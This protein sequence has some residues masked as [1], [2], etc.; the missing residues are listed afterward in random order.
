MYEINCY[1]SYGNIITYLTQWDY[2]RQLSMYLDEYNLL[3]APE[4]H[5]CN[6]N[7]K[8]ALVVQSSVEDSKVTVDIPNILL[9]EHLPLF[10]YV[11]LSDAQNA[12]SQKT[13][14]STTIPIRQRPRPADY[15]Y[16]DNVDIITWAE[17]EERIFTRVSERVSEI[18]ISVAT[19]NTLGGIKAAK[20]TNNETVE[21]KIG[22]NGKLYVPASTN[23]IV[24]TTLTL[25]GTAAD[26]KTVG[27]LINDFEKRIK[28][29]EGAQVTE[30]ELLGGAS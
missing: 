12:S 25:E 4:V 20:K 11:Y 13:I 19:E 23:I 22:A 2:N 15:I 29:L 17:V 10:L 5:F 6:Q 18:S 27:D 3:Y 7:S 21:V 30:T 14:I 28:S 1:D 26:A 24:D 8:E 16:E 9:Q